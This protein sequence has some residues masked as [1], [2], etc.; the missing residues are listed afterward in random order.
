MTDQTFSGPALGGLTAGTLA[1]H[2][3]NINGVTG[4]TGMGRPGRR[5]TR[6]QR[7]NGNGTVSGGQRFNERE[8]GAML[9]VDDIAVLQQL[10]STFDVREDPD[11]VSVLTI[12]GMGYEGVRRAYVL[13]ERFDYKVNNEGTA[14]GFWQCDVAWIAD[15]PNLYA[16]DQVSHIFGT[17][18]ATDGMG[19]SPAGSFTFAATNE[20]TRGA[21]SGRAL[22]LRITA[23]G[24]VVDPYIKIT[25]AG[26]TDEAVTWHRTMTSGQV[27]LTD[28][29]LTARIGELRID[30]TARSGTSP[31]RNWPKFQPG[32]QAF[33]IGCASGTISGYLKTRGIW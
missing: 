10:E 14:T 27:I 1:D 31:F 2:G 5:T 22:E 33:E 16:E 12:S 19:T 17:G 3:I 15:D 18:S 4:V 6:A 7:T 25:T 29:N 20:G 9:G 21:R 11:D 30:G 28:E 8:I 24:T 23:H 13:P 26:R 32:E